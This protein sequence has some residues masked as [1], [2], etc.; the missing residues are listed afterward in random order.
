MDQRGYILEVIDKN[1]ALFK[2]Q[3]QSAWASC[4][5]CFG[6]KTSESQDIVVEVDNR[7]GAKEGQ[8]VEVSMEHINV[9]KAIFIVYGIPLIALIIGAVG[10]Y[11]VMKYLGVGG[12]RQEII[13]FFIGIIFT[14]ISYLII[15]TKDEAFRESR[16]YMPTVVRILVDTD[17]NQKI[18]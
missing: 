6:S 2:M 7:I 10:S 1:T 4:G 15:K 16:K 5:K 9:M 3:R 18:E 17:E 8:S 11:Y 14:G 13:S 12:K